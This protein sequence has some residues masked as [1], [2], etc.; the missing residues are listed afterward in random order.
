MSSDVK[1]LLAMQ[2]FPSNPKRR[3]R[4]EE[5]VPFILR[6]YSDFFPSPLS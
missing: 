3:A 6:L 5:Q 1:G 4:I 2:I